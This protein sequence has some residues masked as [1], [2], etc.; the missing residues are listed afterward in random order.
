MFDHI[1]QGLCRR[2]QKRPATNIWV[3]EGGVMSWA[4]GGGEPWCDLCITEE[5]LVYA[6][7]ILE[8]LPALEVKHDRLRLESARS[9]LLGLLSLRPAA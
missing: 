9:D 6:W 3:G 2:C 4:H 7:Q 1:V 5:Q 8:N